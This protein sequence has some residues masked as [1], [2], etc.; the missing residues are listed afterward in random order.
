MGAKLVIPIAVWSTSV[1]ALDG[2]LV[3]WL[4]E[5]LLA[6]MTWLGLLGMFIL[7][8]IESAGFPIPSEL[9][10]VGAGRLAF[11]GQLHI[12]GLDLTP[13]WLAFIIAI[14][15]GVLGNVLG[16]WIAYL[17]G[18]HAGR[19][20]IKRWG[21]WV[22]LNPK[23][24]A[25]TEDW[26]ERRGEMTVFW[27]QFVPVARTYIS[28]P[29]G[30]G[31]MSQ[32]RF[33]LFTGL[34]SLPFVFLFTWAGFA[35]GQN[36]EAIEPWFVLLDFFA[37]VILGGWVMFMLIRI[38]RQR[39]WPRKVRKGARAAG[40]HA[41]RATLNAGAGVRKASATVAKTGK[42]VAHTVTHPKVMA[43]STRRAGQDVVKQ[44]RKLAETMTD[45]ERLGEVARKAG[46]GVKR[47]SNKVAKAG[48]KA[49]G[50]VAE[51]GLKAGGKVAEA[52]QRAGSKVVEAG[53]K[54]AD[55]LPRP[56]PKADRGGED[57][58]DQDTPTN[59]G[60]GATKI[61]GDDQA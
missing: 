7:M 49:G 27:A 38:G 6:I 18:R 30:M 14:I 28:I 33:M 3:T 34:G 24:L 26:F 55:R 19:P 46:G 59:E 36:V 16:S 53:K 58:G 32:G 41:R 42:A 40:R 31:Q 60:D 4:S 52:G 37:Y 35:F 20:A 2:G 29:A 11:D 9:I 13:P 12:L 5:L 22:M 61:S 56:K 23:H 39:E 8:V 51:A 21:R 57:D 47:A 15:I 50:K 43:A 10:M 54:V 48:L 44:A 25:W 17:I 45:P 1:L